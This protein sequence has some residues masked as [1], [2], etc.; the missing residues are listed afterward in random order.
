VTEIKVNYVFVW[1]S[2]QRGITT[3]RSTNEHFPQLDGVLMNLGLTVVFARGN[4]GTCHPA[5]HGLSI[6]LHSQEE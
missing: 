4:D 6:V 3:Y 1:D 2:F 5:Q